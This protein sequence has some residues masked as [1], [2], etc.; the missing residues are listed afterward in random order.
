M[1]PSKP[2]LR[3]RL[4]RLPTWAL[5]GLAALYIISPVDLVPFFP[6]DD[7]VVFGWTLWTVVRRTCGGG[8]QPAPALPPAGG[9]P[10]TPH[11]APSV[12][13]MLRAE[14]SHRVRD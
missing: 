13:S 4:E 3:A 7:L 11:V 9:P 14:Q 10:P 8:R 2:S 5:M 1:N 6:G 12:E